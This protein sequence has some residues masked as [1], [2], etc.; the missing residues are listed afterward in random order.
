M[1]NNNSFEIIREFVETPITNIMKLY[2]QY[3]QDG[4]MSKENAK[5]GIEV[6]GTLTSPFE[7]SMPKEYIATI[8]EYRKNV[9][10]WAK[11]VIDDLKIEGEGK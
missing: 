6:Y 2:V 11:S 8:G 1:E 5:N 10:R 3:V 4:V 9:I 7:Q